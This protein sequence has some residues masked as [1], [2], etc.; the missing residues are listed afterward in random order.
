MSRIWSMMD[1]G[2]RSMANSQTALATTAHNISNKSTEGYS[3]QRLETVTND[4]LGQGQL[5]IGMGARPGVISRVSDQFLEKNLEREG[6]QLGYLESRSELLGRVEQIYNEQLNEGLTHSMGRMFNAFRE[7]ANN[8]ESLATRTEV[9]ESA[10]G[11]A[12]DFHHMQAQLRDVTRDA[13]FRIMTKVEEVNQLTKEIASLNIKIQSA[14]LGGSTANDER[15]RRDQIL[16]EISK[17]VNIRY[18]ESE[19]GALT[20]TAGSTAVLVSGGSSRDLYAVATPAREGKREDN[21]DIFYKSHDNANP[22]LVNSQLKGGDIGGLLQVRDEIVG[23]LEDHLDQVAFSMASEVNKVHS[24]GYDRLGRTGNLF[25][26]TPIA[27]LGAASALAVDEKLQNDVSFLAG[28]G[29]PGAPGDNRVANLLS[30]IENKKVMANNTST[31]TDFYSATVGKVGIEA[32]RANTSLKSQKE[33]VHQLKN[34]RE[35][36]SGVSLDEETTHLIEYQKAY[37]ASARLIRTVDEMLD[38]LL[39]LKKL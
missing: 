29:E 30:Q 4:A 2:R 8:P 35:S 38:T 17:R 12:K 33:I 5:R 34:Q 20:I 31:L 19:D 18:A 22:V 11:V 13:D 27:K 32:Q 1:I 28:A 26:K 25:F 23:G 3:R 6:N 15:D 24:Q 14:E 9:R 16:K 39:N 37:D 7:F 36:L 10:V 21:V